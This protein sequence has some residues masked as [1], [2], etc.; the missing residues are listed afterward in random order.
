MKPALWRCAVLAV[1]LLFVSAGCGRTPRPLPLAGFKVKFGEQNIPTQMLADK[2]VSADIFV[3]NASGRT[4]P[5]KP[6]QRGRYI[7][8]LTYHWLDQKGQVVVFDGLRTPFPRDLNPGEGVKLNA[9]IRAPEQ[10][11]RYTLEITLVQEAVAWFP[12]RDGG[13]LRVPVEVV[14]QTAETAKPSERNPE[15]PKRKARPGR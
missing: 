3:E 1:A 5:S 4:W 15:P 6:D 12:D 8:H 13:E 11:G 10:P 9:F 7:V 2:T 14:A